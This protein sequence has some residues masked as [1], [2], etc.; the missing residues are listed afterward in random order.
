VVAGSEGHGRG[1][2]NG[3]L[4]YSDGCYPGLVLVIIQKIKVTRPEMASI[5]HRQMC[6]Q[7]WNHTIMEIIQDTDSQFHWRFDMEMVIR[8]GDRWHFGTFE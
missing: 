5:V 4:H 2:V 6:T 3:A 8:W 1:G 7:V